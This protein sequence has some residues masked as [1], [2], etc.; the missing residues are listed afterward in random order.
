MAFPI[1]ITSNSAQPNTGGACG[2]FKI[3]SA[4][5]V[6][7][8]DFTNG[9]AIEAWK[10]TDGGNTWVLKDSSGS[11]ID[12]GNTGDCAYCT[13]GS[14]IYVAYSVASILTISTFDPSTDTWTVTVSSGRT[15]ETSGANLGVGTCLAIGWDAADSVCIV[16][17]ADHV[18]TTGGEQRTAYATYNPITHGVAGFNHCGGST[19]AWAGN[20]VLPGSGRMHFIFTVV[21]PSGN[22][23]FWQQAITGT[24]TLGTLQ[25]IG[26]IGSGFGFLFGIFCFS[27]GTNIICTG[28]EPFADSNDVLTGTS[29]DPIVFSTVTV[30]LPG[31]ATPNMAGTVLSSGVQYLIASYN[32]GGTNTIGLAIKSGASFGAFTTLGTVGNGSFLYASNVSGTASPWSL[33]SLGSLIFW[34]LASTPPPTSTTPVILNAGGAISLP[35]PKQSYL[36]RWGPYQRCMSRRMDMT[37]HKR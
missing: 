3:G 19:N 5:Y 15:I 27:D 17:Y 35:D 2:P 29:A 1:V 16:L 18:F 24:V 4:L 11:P 10:S 34:Q 36:C 28:P 25:Q 6:M 12:D 33:V 20:A 30:N 37:I 8:L 22:V 14:K 31:S 7:T 21:D 9:S 23:T 26:S 13:D 32:N